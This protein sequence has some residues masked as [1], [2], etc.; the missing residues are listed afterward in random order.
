MLSDN[1]SVGDISMIDV[2]EAKAQGVELLSD[3]E[4]AVGNRTAGTH[5]RRL[6][7]NRIAIKHSRHKANQRK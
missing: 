5:R 7:R 3:Q 4:G 1:V 6:W 2:M